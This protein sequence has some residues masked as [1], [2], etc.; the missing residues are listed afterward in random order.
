MGDHVEV[1][2]GSA[3]DLPLLEPLWLAMHHWHGSVM[4]DLAPY[5]SDEQSWAE[6]RKLY[7]QLLTK[8]D[9]VLLLALA[10]DVPVG[11]GLAHVMATED[12]WVADSWKTGARIGEVESLGVLPAF[13]GHGLGTRL[14]DALLDELTASGVDDLILGVLAGNT[15]AMRLYQRKGF[16]P[17]WLYLTRFAGR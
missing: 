14:L 17:T 11:Y 9:T 10:D 6:R 3:V 8:P 12:T 7:A 4:P 15:D 13:R 2:R 1:R 5:V 16:Q